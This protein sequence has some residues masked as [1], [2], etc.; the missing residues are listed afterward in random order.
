[1]NVQFIDFSEQY[2]LVKNE[3]RILKMNLPN[4]VT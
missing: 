3:P 4:I 1:M 2:K